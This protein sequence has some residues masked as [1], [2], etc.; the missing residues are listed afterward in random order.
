MA[1]RLQA[2]GVPAAAVQDGRDLVEHDPQLRARGF[3]Q[4]LEHPRAG[5]FLHEGIPIRLSMT[6]GG[7]RDPAPLLGADTDF[8]LHRLGGYTSAEID[9][10]RASGTLE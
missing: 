3:Y 10:L 5:Q 1:E 9:E 2:A 8:V 7:L 6:P 4:L